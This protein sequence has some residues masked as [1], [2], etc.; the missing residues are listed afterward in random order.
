[1]VSNVA[2]L[3][4]LASVLLLIVASKSR[5]EL[6]DVDSV[7]PELL[8][9]PIQVDT[10]IEPFSFA[11]AGKSYTV[12]PVADYELWGLVVSHNDIE[13]FM[14]FVHDASSVD[15]KDLCVIWGPNLETNDFQQI[16][17][18]SGDFTCFF[19]FPS[20]V[21]FR[22]DSISNNHLITDNQSIRDVIAN[23]RVGDQVHILGSLVNYQEAGTTFWRRSSTKRR[24]SGN[25]ACEVIF[26]DEIEI[27]EQGTPVWYALYPLAWILVIFSVLARVGLF[28][29]KIVRDA[30]GS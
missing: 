1:M 18:T 17:F 22:F 14:D 30:P 2:T 29:W 3:V 25:G 8:Q 16:E 28:V 23:I 21:D 15:T 19:Q 9:E 26:V 4:I 6:V 10:E 11:Y 12:E 24:D 13:S 20:G 7:R 27:I 5:G